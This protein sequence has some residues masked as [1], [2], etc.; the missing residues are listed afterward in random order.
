VG[1]FGIFGLSISVVVPRSCCTKRLAELRLTAKVRLLGTV[2]EL[3]NPLLKYR[4]VYERTR[5]RIAHSVRQ[6]LWKYLSLIDEQEDMSVVCAITSICVNLSYMCTKWRP[7]VVRRATRVEVK[8]S[9]AVGKLLFVRAP[10]CSCLPASS[11]GMS[12]HPVAP[13]CPCTL[14]LPTP[15][16]VLGSGLAGDRPA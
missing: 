15:G 7:S 11:D 13:T 2:R 3:E 12:L 10:G 8:P 6:L 9:S 4:C 5:V 1:T 14:L 16:E